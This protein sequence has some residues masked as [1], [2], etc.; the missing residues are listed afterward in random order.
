M[1]LASAGITANVI[2][3]MMPEYHLSADLLD[4]TQ[5]ALPP[6][7]QDA[8]ASWRQ[9]RITRLVGEITALLPA[10]AA[11]ARL[12]A[13]IIVV[14]ELADTMTNRAYAPDVT[15]EQMCRLGRTSAE[16]IRT[17][18]LLERTLARRQMKPTPFFG[19]VAADEV[20]IA[21]LDAVWCKRTV[22]SAGAGPMQQTVT[23]PQVGGEAAAPK[24]PNGE[25]PRART[26]IAPDAQAAA[27]PTLSQRAGDRGHAPAPR[28]PPEARPALKSEAMDAMA[29][30]RDE[31][32]NP[33]KASSQ[34]P[35]GA[36]RRV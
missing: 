29:G 21:A 23:E 27:R 35:A 3:E 1:S 2:Q 22:A 4:G 20:D 7:P 5:K 8:P 16:L 32:G 34:P 24:Q 31:A 28:M 25:V 18:A 36:C 33:D 26:E 15:V 12:A 30:A 17:A 10:D 11:Q 14:R 6:P 9:A 19:S 13:Q